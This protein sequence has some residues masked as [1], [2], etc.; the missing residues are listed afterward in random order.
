ML[1][2]LEFCLMLSQNWGNVPVGTSVCKPMYA[3][4]DDTDCTW[5]I[6]HFL[7]LPSGVV[8]QTVLSFRIPATQ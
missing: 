1:A 5:W 3:S 8:S 2:L 7:S 4:R 6:L